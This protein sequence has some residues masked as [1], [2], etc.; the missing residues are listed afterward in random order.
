MKY[1]RTFIRAFFLLSQLALAVYF[2]LES[3]DSWNSSP[4]VTSVTT[5][6]ISDVPFPAITI[7][8]P[9]NGKW[10]ALAKAVEA[11]SSK[12]QIYDFVKSMSKD[13]KLIVGKAFLS[14]GRIWVKYE[15]KGGTP[16]RH[17]GVT[18]ML[19]FKYGIHDVIWILLN[20]PNL[21]MAL[22]V[23]YALFANGEPSLLHELM[24]EVLVLIWCL[25]IKLK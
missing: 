25:K 16:G 2:T 22:M 3:V 8:P 19:Y 15:A 5:K 10:M 13:F 6:P 17:L 12:K 18:D 7:C 1:T 9:T 14:K 23:H 4:V 21:E 11:L 24:V 20:E